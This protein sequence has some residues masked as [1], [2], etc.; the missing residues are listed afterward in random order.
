MNLITA[1]LVK[2]NNNGFYQFKEVGTDRLFSVPWK[3]IHYCDFPPKMLD[4]DYLKNG[5]EIKMVEKI[6]SDEKSLFFPA[7]QC[8]PPKATFNLENST[9]LN[10]LSQEDVKVVSINS[11]EELHA[12]QDEFCERIEQ[13]DLETRRTVLTILS[14]HDLKKSCD[15]LRKILNKSLFPEENGSIEYKSSFIH[16]ADP[17][18]KGD[19]KYQ[20]HEL[21]KVLISFANSQTHSGT[22]FVGITD[23]QQIC[24]VENEI[25]EFNPSFNRERFSNMFINLVKQLSNNGLWIQTAFQWL[26]IEQHLVARIYVNYHGDVVLFNSSELYVRKEG[27]VYK[28]SGTDMIEFIRNT[29]NRVIL[30]NQIK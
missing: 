8:Y 14:G 10:Q 5:V 22:L 9:V 4:G 24:G 12:L 1:I 3:S 15:Y 6:I 2:Y 20:L 16:P 21:V 26:K 30:S 29:E 19:Y 28:L 23:E 11:T 13:Y 25:Q 18:Y 17:K 7:H 27:G